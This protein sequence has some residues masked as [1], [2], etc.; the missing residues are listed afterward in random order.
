MSELEVDAPSVAPQPA[1]QCSEIA[2]DLTALDPDL[3]LYRAAEARNL[4]VMLQ[5]LALGGRPA[6][7]HPDPDGKTPLIK[8]I[9]SVSLTIM[10]FPV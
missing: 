6:W 9:A 5:A 4:P 10:S 1:A 8:A 3:L 7:H 2:D